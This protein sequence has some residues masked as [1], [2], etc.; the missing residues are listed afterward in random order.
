MPPK[1][2]DGFVIS[3]PT[4][5]YGT[6]RRLG[7]F[8]N[9]WE[10]VEVVAVVVV[11]LTIGLLDLSENRTHLLSLWDELRFDG[12]LKDIKAQL[13][14]KCR[15]EVVI[16]RKGEID[17]CIRNDTRVVDMSEASTGDGSTAIEIEFRKSLLS[18]RHG[19]CKI[20]LTIFQYWK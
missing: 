4:L 17:D 16:Y 19:H 20:I 3:V 8:S 14:Y 9:D 15:D 1:V 13:D 10:L 2:L 18:E 7:A 12:I 6:S 11:V 5:S